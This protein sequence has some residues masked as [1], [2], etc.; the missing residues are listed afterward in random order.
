[1]DHEQALLILNQLRNKELESYR[2]AKEDFH[3][4]RTILLKQED[5]IDFRGNAQHRGE[6]IYTFEPGWTK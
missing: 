4:F 5:A 3:M 6:T 2:V 1:M